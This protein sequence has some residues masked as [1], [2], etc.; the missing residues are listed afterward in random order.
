MYF[1]EIS[2]PTTNPASNGIFLYAKDDGAGVT[3]LFTMDSNGTESQL[4]TGGGGG[5]ATTLDALNDVTISSIANLNA[6]IYNA[7]SSQWENVALDHTVHLSN[8]GTNT[9]AQIDSHISASTSVHGITNTSDLALISG[10]VAQFAN[11]SHTVL[12]DIGTNTHAQI[13]THIA[14][15]GIHPTDSG[16]VH[17]TGNE[18]VNGIKTFGSIPILPASNPTT[19]N[20]AVRKAYVD[21]IAMGLIPKDACV[22]ATTGNITLS[23][24]Q[25]IDG[26]SVVA[27]NRVLVK[28]Q[29]TGTQNGIYV[30]SAGAWSRATDYDASAE[31]QEG[32]FTFVS[33]GTVNGGY[34]FVQLTVDPILD[35]NTLSFSQVGQTT[36]YTGS[37]GVE[38]VGNDFRADLL[39]SGALGLTGNELKVNVDNS[40]IEISSNALQIKALGVTNAMLAG[41]IDLT[42]KVTGDL[43]FAN[44]AQGSALSVLGVTGNST[45]DVASIAAGSDHQ[46]LRRSGTAL[47]FGAVNL[48]SAN[49]VTGLLPSA[50]LATVAIAQG[51]T[52]ITTYTTGDLLYASATNTLSKLGIGAEGTVL[53]VASGVPVWATATGGSGA[54]A[55]GSFAIPR[56]DRRKVAFENFFGAGSSAG[57]ASVSNSSMTSTTNDSTIQGGTITT[58]AV[59]GSQVYARVLSTVMYLLRGHSPTYIFHFKTG[60]DITATRIWAGLLSAAPTNADTLGTTHG[61]A[62]RYSSVAGDTTWKY[63]T[64]DGSSQTV[65]DSGL[66]VAINTVYTLKIVVDA[67]VPNVTFTLNGGNSQTITTTLP[68]A[69]TALGIYNAL[70]G[71]TT[72]TRS[73]ILSRLYCEWE[74][75]PIAD[76]AP[77]DATYVTLGTSSGLSNERVLTAGEGIDLTD[78]GAGS[79]I[80]VSG[81][82]ATDSNKGIVELAIASEVNTGTDATRAIT[83][84]ALAGSNAGIRYINSSLNGTTALTTSE[85]V[86]FRIPAAFNGMNL[87]SVTASVGTGAAGSSSSGT[88]TFTVKNVTDNNQMLSTSLTVDA[89]EYT[90]ATAAVAAV[91]DTTKDDVATDDLIEIAVTTSGTGVTYANVTCGFQL[92]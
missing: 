92:P 32:T 27:G 41:S 40:S 52:N 3:V 75:S 44:L 56:A 42:T 85:K 63:I 13:D 22:A 90:S 31:V 74:G 46:V 57:F 20:Q 69:T 91:I 1:A 23:G 48:A 61:L 66:S 83:P 30:A 81:E 37:L 84:D 16:L 54:G 53:T 68:G 21:S 25:T 64:S 73:M 7:T 76:T 35:T 62:L 50:N 39:A 29:S 60:P 88:P 65:T 87:V 38:L 89:N 45:A 14:N 43:P 2:T 86:Y 9:H 8:V 36:S 58:G 19:D 11:H 55:G 24:E 51:G 5:G 70:I 77:A 72:S 79:T 26:V 49:A 18:T 34:Q 28:N 15:S 10:S 4:G 12:T 47:A 80:T 59:A 33:S 6:L 17:T 71:T 78:A 82:D 67:S